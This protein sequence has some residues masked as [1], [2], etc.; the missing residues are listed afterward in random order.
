MGLTLASLLPDFR[1]S[2][3]DARKVFGE[4]GTPEQEANLSR[5]LRAAAVALAT[6][7]RPRTRQG[8]IELV[9][10]VARYT[11]GLPADLLIPKVGLWG[12]EYLAEPWCGPRG[13]LPTLSLA[14]ADEDGL[15]ALVLTPAPTA[16]QIAAYGSAYT[17]YY[18]ASHQITDAEATSTLQERDR[19]LVILRAQVEAMRETAMRNAHKPVTLREGGGGVGRNTTPAALYERLLAEYERAA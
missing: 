12:S 19:A 11:T 4:D 13:P 16:A 7:K 17:F 15:Q 9:A 8:T 10:G 2:L 1:A 14:D 6:G 5:H 18:F 3:N